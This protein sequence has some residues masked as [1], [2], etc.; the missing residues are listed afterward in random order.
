MDFDQPL[1]LRHTKHYAVFND[2]QTPN[3]LRTDL[4]G[5]YQTARQAFIALK[6]L[7]IEAYDGYIYPKAGNAGF[8]YDNGIG[9]LRVVDGP[10]VGWGYHFRIPE[11]NVVI[12]L[13]VKAT[14]VFHEDL[15]PEY[16]DERASASLLPDD[17]TEWQLHC[18]IPFD[19]VEGERAVQG[20]L[21][22][23][24]GPQAKDDDSEGRDGFGGRRV[25]EVD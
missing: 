6:K 8:V 15:D 10:Y 2:Q 7:R 19:Q 5:V 25:S 1:R 3:S 17:F 18:E 11:E 12:T 13:R 20:E 22:N 16:E 23:V 14:F 21:H 4:H 9:L 24:N